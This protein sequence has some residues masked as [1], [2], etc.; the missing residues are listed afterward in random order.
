MIDMYHYFLVSFEEPDLCVGCFNN[1]CY[2]FVDLWVHLER[3]HQH[4][5]IAKISDGVLNS[6]EVLHLTQHNYF[7]FRDPC[8]VNLKLWTVDGC[9]QLASKSNF[10]ELVFNLNYLENLSF[11]KPYFLLSFHFYVQI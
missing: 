3:N 2:Y 1:F 8:L 9:D 4:G 6:L 11:V 5:P 10:M 7:N